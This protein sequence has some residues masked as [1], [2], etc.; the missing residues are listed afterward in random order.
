MT[1]Y[2]PAPLSLSAFTTQD[3]NATGR[4]VTTSLRDLYRRMSETPDSYNP[5]AFLQVCPS[6]TLVQIR[7]FVLR[8]LNSRKEVAR[9]TQ[10]PN[11]TLRSAGL[12][13]SQFSVQTSESLSKRNLSSIHSWPVQ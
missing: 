9:Q 3:I 4:Q 11:K 12:K 1:S 5:N 10:W 13:S 2:T 8:S 6:L 7:C